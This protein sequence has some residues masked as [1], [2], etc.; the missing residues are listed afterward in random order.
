MIDE[1]TDLD[2]L[3]LTYPIIV[4]PTDRSGSRGI[5]KLQSPEGLDEAVRNAIG[6]SFEKKALIEEFAGGQER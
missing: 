6:C 5:H 1:N 3:K 2:S 4:K